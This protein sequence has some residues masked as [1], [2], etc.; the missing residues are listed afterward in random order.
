MTSAGPTMRD[1]APADTSDRE[2]VVTRVCDAPRA[3]VRD[4]DGSEASCALVGAE[5]FHAHHIR[6]GVQARR[7][8]AVRDA[9]TQGRNYQHKVVYVEIA[10]SERLI[11]RHPSPP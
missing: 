8:L 11:Y 4:V 7:R 9:R 3:R 1:S 2:I 6:D 5:R 10:D